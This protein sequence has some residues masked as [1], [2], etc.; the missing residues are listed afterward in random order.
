M[1]AELVAMSGATID[2]YLRTAKAGEQIKGEST[3]KPSRLLRSSITI[4]K[5]TDEVE[6]A[7][8]FF[9]GDTVAHCGPT[10][11][12]RVRPHGQL[13]RHAYRLGVHPQCAQQRPYPHPGRTEGRDT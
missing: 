6:A 3:T 10:L 7:P 4:R 13:H 11:K 1:R 2:R 9:E 8:G 12:R 5:A